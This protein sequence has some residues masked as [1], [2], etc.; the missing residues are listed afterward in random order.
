MKG[1]NIILVGFMGSGKTAVGRALARLTGKTMIDL[2]SIIEDRERMS[3]AAIF[4]KYG[5]QHFRD[6]EHR[7]VRAISHASSSVVAVGGG[8]AVFSRNRV[9]LR[10]AGIVVYLRVPL[11]VLVSRLLRSRRR[12][13]LKPAGGSKPAVKRIVRALLRKRV[14]AYIRTAHITVNG[15]NGNTGTVARRIIEQVKSKYGGRYLAGM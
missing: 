15:G 7:E 1:G 13:L 14:G 4:K 12:P 9:W 6:I 10:K 8:A 11:A 2:D 5:E 3:I